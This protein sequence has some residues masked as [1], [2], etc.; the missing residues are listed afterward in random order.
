M[1]A[2]PP[3]WS[4]VC[5]SAQR[6]W[7]SSYFTWA[8]GGQQPFEGLGEGHIQVA[9]NSGPICVSVYSSCH[10]KAIAGRILLLLGGVR[11]AGRFRGRAWLGPPLPAFRLVLE[12]PARPRPIAGTIGDQFRGKAGMCR[13]FNGTG[14]EGDVTHQDSGGGPLSPDR[15]PVLGLAAALLES[16]ADRTGV[17]GCRSGARPGRAQRARRRPAV[18]RLSDAQTQELG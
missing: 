11:C 7:S 17:G 9:S 13:V 3:M 10:G 1:L 2:Y 14:A 6:W 18:S 16:A 8:T 5:Y 15:N 4:V 12:F